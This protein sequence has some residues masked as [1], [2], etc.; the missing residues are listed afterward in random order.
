[1]SHLYRNGQLRWPN[2][3]RSEPFTRISKVIN[4]QWLIKGQQGQAQY[5]KD[6]PKQYS[7]ASQAN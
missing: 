1:M 7:E 5:R 3:A 2:C 6:Q 4:N